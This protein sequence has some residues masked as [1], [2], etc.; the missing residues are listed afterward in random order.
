MVDGILDRLTTITN[1]L[2]PTFE[3]FLKVTVL[4]VSET[5]ETGNNLPTAQELVDK[6]TKMMT[7]KY[8]ATALTQ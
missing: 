6:L 7:R 1:A 5:Y 3:E 2:C 4:T 8:S